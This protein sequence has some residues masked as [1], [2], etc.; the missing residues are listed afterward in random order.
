VIGGVVWGLIFVALL[1]PWFRHGRCGPIPGCVVT[2]WTWF[3]YPFGWEF[4]G[5]FPYWVPITSGSIGS[6][7]G[8]AIVTVLYRLL[9]RTAVRRAV[10]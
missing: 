10:G 6:A 9:E 7:V 5:G 3:N 4:R 2:W 1:T 8:W